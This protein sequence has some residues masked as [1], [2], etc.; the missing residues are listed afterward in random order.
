MPILGINTA[1]GNGSGGAVGRK[2][3]TLTNVV[4]PSNGVT[5]GIYIYVH[6]GNPA[7]N[8]G[9]VAVYDGS[10]NLRTGYGGEFVNATPGTWAF[11]PFVQPIVAGQT[12]RP[13]YISNGTVGTSYENTGSQDQGYSAVGYAS[14]P[15]ASLTGLA[16]QDYTI[17][18]YI[19][20]TAD[21]G[22]VSASIS[23]QT[24]Q[25]T[26]LATLQKIAPLSMV[27]QTG[28]PSCAVLVSTEIAAIT[29]SITSQTGQPTS[30]AFITTD[31]TV[32]VPIR[33]YCIGS[34]TTAG[35]PH[36]EL[37]GYR[38]I[39]QDL[40]RNKYTFDFVGSQ[41]D[42]PAG[43]DNNHSGLGGATISGALNLVQTELAYYMSNLGDARGFVVLQIG[44]ADVY[45]DG[46]T[47]NYPGYALVY[48]QILDYVHNFNPNIRVICINCKPI[49]G[50][51]AA[52]ARAN[53]LNGLIAN[54]I[55]PRTSYCLY[56]DI[57]TPI[58]NTTNW[59]TLL[60]EE[61]THLS[62]AGYQML[63]GI[64]YEDIDTPEIIIASQTGQPSASVSLQKVEFISVVA[65]I[66]QPVCV[67]ALQAI[68]N[69]TI[70]SQ[71]GQ[72]TCSSNL[73][74]VLPSAIASQTGQPSA[75][76][77]VQS[78]DVLSVN[79]ITAQPMCAMSI[80]TDST[81]DLLIASQTS[82]P[83]TII[84]LQKVLTISVLSQAGQPV[85]SITIGDALPVTPI[86]RKI[87]IHFTSRTI[88]A[89]GSKM[90]ETKY[91]DPDATLDYSIDWTEWLSGD[92]IVSS[93][94][95]ADTGITIVRSSN[96]Q[97]ITTVWLSGGTNNMS[98]IVTNR[99]TTAAGR[100]DDR[101]F[102]LSITNM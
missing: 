2:L 81:A 38:S 57:Y 102:K 34:S 50:D 18:M 96:S 8:R 22:V 4:A 91:K 59:E 93:I 95:T 43:Y 62:Q 63:A 55:S 80:V 56:S 77:V 48:S 37:G 84:A 71:T 53:Y 29:L 24:G 49:V 32:L 68:V 11:V 15:S 30:T 40:L 88:K 26:A 6:A 42:G 79:S 41:Y 16:F 67:A 25:P 47:A 45:F 12:Y 54:Y 70:D 86:C 82:Q 52:S 20:Y 19:N 99:I 39:V 73:Q 66:G 1:Y 27:A 13:C 89:G 23:S 72:P 90:I 58:V 17:S 74:K 92:T 35:L 3:C 5:T 78:I 94:W 28:Q 7:T 65:Q 21:A 64:L 97:Q 76:V 44:D 46:D 9:K 100:I 10:G 98:Y 101:S 61:Q 69:V 85:A 75:S 36:P 51:P 33:L 83:V 60:Y 14:E 31:S 87:I